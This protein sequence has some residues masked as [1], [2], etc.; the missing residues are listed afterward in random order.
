M[1]NNRF[2]IVF[3]GA[4]L[5]GVEQTTAQFNL[6][7]LFKTDVASVEKLFSGRPIALKRDLSSAEAHSYLEALRKTGID[8]RIEE[9]APVVEL[10]L[11]D[12]NEL[13][14]SVA[15]PATRIADSPYAPPTAQVGDSLPTFGPLKAFTIKG[16]IGRLRYLAWSM[17]ATFIAIIAVAVIAIVLSGS[18][19]A[20]ISLALIALAVFIVVTVQIAIQRLH[21][22]GWSGW[23]WLLT[24]VPFVG[25]VFPFVL[26]FYPGNA[27]ANQYGAP[28]PPNSTAVKVLSVLAVIGIVA[29]IVF[30]AG[31]GV[32]DIEDRYN[33]EAASQSDNSDEAA[34]AAAPAVDYEKE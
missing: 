7:E 10:S 25:S 34:E 17:V 9:E 12:I 11:A 24:L 26:M 4:L 32:K 14:A 13:P 30:G 22:I 27:G 3:D 15:P 18:N 1:S 21:D 23:L 31:G 6:A 33:N 5:P 28:P 20:G 29:I 19:F 16:R 2:K 8:A